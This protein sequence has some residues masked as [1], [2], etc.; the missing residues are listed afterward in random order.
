MPNVSSRSSRNTEQMPFTRECSTT[1]DIVTCCCLPLSE[2]FSFDFCFPQVHASVLLEVSW[3]YARTSLNVYFHQTRRTYGTQVN[4]LLCWFALNFPALQNLGKLGEPFH[5]NFLSPT[6]TV[7][8]SNDVQGL[9]DMA[10]NNNDKPGCSSVNKMCAATNSCSYYYMVILLYLGKLL[11][12]L[13][14]HAPST[15]SDGQDYKHCKLRVCNAVQYL[16][17][18]GT[19]SIRA[20]YESWRYRVIF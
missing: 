19:A 9:G 4:T 15:I 17:V 1:E 8:V 18:R 5:S 20:C 13:C 11:R 7:H 16:G 2:I 6:F 12:L 3:S 14:F 10:H